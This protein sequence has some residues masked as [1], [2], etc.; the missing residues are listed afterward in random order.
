VTALLNRGWFFLEKCDC[1]AQSFGQ[2][3]NR[4]ET[5]NNY[6]QIVYCDVPSTRDVEDSGVGIFSANNVLAATISF[7]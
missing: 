5:A 6:G 3:A 2:I 4:T 7:T 1:C